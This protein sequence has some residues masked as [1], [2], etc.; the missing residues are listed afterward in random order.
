MAI[1][2]YERTGF[3]SIDLR[4]YEENILGE[5]GPAAERLGCTNDELLAVFA[6]SDRDAIHETLQVNGY[7]IPSW[8]VQV[9][10]LDPTNRSRGGFEIFFDV[11]GD[12][13]VDKAKTMSAKH[14]VGA[15]GNRG[16]K[17]GMRVTS[18]QKKG[19]SPCERQKLIGMHALAH[20]LHP[21]YNVGATDIGT[22]GNDMD[23]IAAAL[24]ERHGI[25]A[26]AAA[27]GVS[28]YYGGEP[29]LQAPRTGL[30]ASIILDRYFQKRAETD[31][32]VADA[33]NGGRPLRALVQGV[34]KAGRHF[35]STM[36]PY[37]QLAGAMEQEG[38]ITVEKGIL[39]RDRVLELAEET[40]FSAE[41]VSTV[42]GAAWLSPDKLSDF[43]ATK[44]VDIAVPAF[45]CF[46]F[47]ERDAETFEGK[48]VLSIANHP[49]DAGAQ[50]VLR[51]KR[52]DELVDVAANI[53]GTIS[54]EFIWRKFIDPDN[55]T[56]EGFEKSWR[57]S[58]N[59]VA[60]TLLTRR[61]KEAAE[62]STFFSFQETANLIV[63]ERA[64]Q[65]LRAAA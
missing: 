63:I 14:E 12:K 44:D 29:K 65:R 8:R 46:Q 30:G 18:E 13:V 45:N 40:K 55:W 48:V 47:N 36:P 27:S 10:I 51:Q 4:A 20:N 24:V 22:D 37:V 60:S 64:I 5:Y 35:I 21:L 34:G 54:S 2:P 25:L 31:S 43:W 42:E 49:L 38:A 28:E 50:A 7:K 15:T 3:E 6:I 57:Q 56:R 16:A 62:Q 11:T 17:S 61:E 9:G 1:A 19:L 33:I 52:I 41:G 59:T 53:G 58:M 39:K 23:A 32:R 26:G